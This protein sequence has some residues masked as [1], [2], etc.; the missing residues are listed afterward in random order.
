[1]SYKKAPQYIVTNS[2]VQTQ[3]Y[4]NYT[5]IEYANSLNILVKYDS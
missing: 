1:M 4:K 2:L 3:K 5:F